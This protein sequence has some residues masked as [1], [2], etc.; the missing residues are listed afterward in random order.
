VYSITPDVDNTVTNFY[1]TGTVFDGG[2]VIQT[3][4]VTIR[5][6]YHTDHN[7]NVVGVGYY[8]NNCFIDISPA[9][10][11]SLFPIEPQI[12]ATIQDEADIVSEPTNAILRTNYAVCEN[13]DDALRYGMDSIMID[14]MVPSSY[15]PSNEDPS[16][17]NGL[18]R[19]LAICHRPK[20]VSI[21]GFFTDVNYTGIVS[22]KSSLYNTNTCTYNTGTVAF[23][24]NKTPIYRDYLVQKEVF[25]LII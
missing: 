6:Y 10:T 14:M 8:E 24:S 17:Y 20:E 3:I 11:E 12:E 21:N 9:L 13:Y 15:I 1:N 4:D 16:L 5:H 25:K 7:I 19:Q 2:S 18:Y 23:L 22:G